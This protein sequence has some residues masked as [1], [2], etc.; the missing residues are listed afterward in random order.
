MTRRGTSR[1]SA[2]RRLLS[3]AARVGVRPFAQDEL[4]R[5]SFYLASSTFTMGA[6]GFAFWFVSAR[7]FTPSQ[8]GLAT[9]LISAAGIVSCIG[10]VGMNRTFVRFLP[11]SQ[12]RDTEISS[13]LWIV[14]AATAVA[15]TI[16]LLLV[17]ALVPRLSFVRESPWLGLGFVAM[18]T[19]AAVNLVTD[20]VFIAYRKTHYNLLIDGVLQGLTKLALPFF[21]IGLGAYGMFAASGLA[22]TVALGASIAFVVR[23]F[24][25]RPRVV[26]SF[27][28]LAEAWRFSAASYASSLLYLCPVFTVPLIVL[29]V[30]GPSQAAYYYVAFQFAYLLSAFVDAV[31]ISL[32]AEGSQKGADLPALMRRSGKLVAL[33]CIPGGALVAASG[34]W[35]LLVFGVPYSQNA[36]VTLAVL[37]AATPAVGLYEWGSAVLF[38]RKRLRT[39]VLINTVFAAVTIGLAFVW[40]RD[41]LGWVAAAWLCGNLCAGIIAATAATLR[42][43]ATNAKVDLARR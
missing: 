39:L 17:P 30:R 29:N 43:K 32:L 3:R 28:F 22:A 23:A 16:Y 4:L 14:F 19:F 37:A 31:A 34:H 5:N 10:L 26:V 9:A 40:S 18:T 42:P 27:R 25:Y 13:G 8:V 12:A 33:V 6:L 36:T 20:S 11:S 15:A 24:D 41:G 1:S 21:L 38:I 7:L 35:L 2:L